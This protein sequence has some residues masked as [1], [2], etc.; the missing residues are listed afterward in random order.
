MNQPTYTLEGSGILWMA[1][2][3]IYLNFEKKYISFNKS[4]TAWP[5]YCYQNGEN[6]LHVC[7]CSIQ[8]YTVTQLKIHTKNT[9]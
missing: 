1:C 8:F 3:H 4:L 6:N 2:F 5:K 9:N 7:N